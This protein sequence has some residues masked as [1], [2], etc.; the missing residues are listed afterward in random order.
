MRKDLFL[1]TDV[2]PEEIPLLFSNKNVYLNFSETQI[3][4]D[5]K[6][7]NLLESIT[8]PYF[9]N[10]PKGEEGGT[11]Q[12][13]LL[14]PLAQLHLFKY[15]SKF[16]QL[17]IAHSKKSKYSVRAPIKRNF[18]KLLKNEKV[19]KE[20]KKLQQEYGFLNKFPVTTDEDLSLY[21]NYFSFNKHK[22]II[23]L[24]TSPSF[25]R[26]QYKFKYFR[27]LDIQNF[28][29]SIYTHSLS[30]ALFGEKSLG[31]KYMNVHD[32][33]PN[34]TDS[35]MQ[36]I[37]F[38]ET[39]GIVVGPEISRVIS[40]M[41]LI[42]IDRKLLLYLEDKNLYHQKDYV[43]YRFLDD[44]FIFTYNSENI[45][46]IEEKLQ[47][48]L[49]EFNLTL[50]IHKSELQ[51]QPFKISNGAISELRGIISQF[52]HSKLVSIYRNTISETHDNSNSN[53]PIPF[54]DYK[55]TKAQWNDLFIKLELLIESYPSDQSK[56]THY[57]LK[58]I[59]GHIN[60]NGKQIPIFKHILEVISNIY[61][62]TITHKSTN[63]LIAIFFK[64]QQ[65]L[66]NYEKN[67]KRK[68]PNSSENEKKDI[69]RDLNQ[70]ESLKESMYHHLY[71]V[72][73]NNLNKM[74]Y[75]YDILIFA[76]S[77]DKK[78]PA[79]FLSS[80]IESHLHSYFVLCSVAYYIL[81]DE[82]TDLNPIYY[83]VKSKLQNQI[84][85]ILSNYK[86][87][88]IQYNKI[89]FESE[90]FYFLNDFAKYPGFDKKVLKSFKKELESAWKKTI[91]GQEEA[92]K[93]KEIEI[94]KK[95]TNHPYYQWSAKNDEFV[96]K[97]VKKSSNLQQKAN[98]YNN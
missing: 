82:N 78:L 39:N 11:R 83:T 14:H 58:T 84:S 52:E 18:P 70:I 61:T 29:P 96:R 69:Q 89:I 59:R 37:N 5:Y 25:K 79:N 1:R 22:T 46:M 87:R 66:N 21:Y 72:M 33:F 17:I 76:K 35:T 43:I 30:W 95:L 28:F 68:I 49:R 65:L 98:F 67:L 53:I 31:K 94:W 71:R 92:K 41:L 62:L 24:I 32:I 77:L 91:T 10:I 19:E 36:K 2:L 4:N 48:L 15:V 80:I 27:K 12:L 42:H 26:T 63:Y 57:F 34:D 50:N 74:D 86:S 44:Y 56:I 55:G 60:F 90:Y 3:H 9:F 20:H 64:L 97:I 47:L 40:E 8:I 54:S 85:D 45:S 88:G 6:G 51:T 81:N 38:K 13:S 93:N 7:I 73:K 23:S 75:M 16:D